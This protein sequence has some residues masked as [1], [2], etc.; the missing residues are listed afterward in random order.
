MNHTISVVIPSYNRCDFL[1]RALDSVLAQSLQPREIIVIDD[2]STDATADIVS[3]RYPQITYAFQPNQGVSAARNHGIKLSSGDWIAFLDSDDTWQPDKLR[4]QSEMITKCPDYRLIHTN[5]VWIRN[6]TELGQMRKHKKRGGY[7]YSDCLPLC[8]ISPSSAMM[9]R[10]IFEDAGFFDEDLPACEDYDLWLRICCKY[11][12]LYS[13]KILVTKYGGHSDQL[14]KKY[15]GMDRFRIR[16]LAKI[17]RTEVLPDHLR[18]MTLAMLQQKV[19]ILL[20]GAIKHGNQDVI[21]EFSA[22]Q[23]IE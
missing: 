22:L 21:S 7:I 6:G 16:S 17:L 2:G 5:E 1:L 14:S 15:W 13:E 4:I 18:K 19:D 9:H 20:T 11:P 12:V 10:S 23:Q 8:V 3:Q